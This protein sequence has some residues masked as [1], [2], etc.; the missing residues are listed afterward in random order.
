MRDQSRRHVGVQAVLK[1]V[2][3]LVDQTKW[4]D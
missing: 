2:E 4:V 3:G 1:E